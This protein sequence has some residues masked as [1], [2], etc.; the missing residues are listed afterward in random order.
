MTAEKIATDPTDEMTL[1]PLPKDTQQISQ[2][3]RTTPPQAA[4]KSSGYW[5][6]EVQHTPSSVDLLNLLR[7]YRT[8]EKA[9][10]ERTRESMRMGETDLVAL[11]HLLK[12]KALG[13]MLRQRDLAELLHISGA[14]VSVLVNRL[15]RDG[16]VS[17]VP[18]PEDRRSVAVQIQASSEEEVR[19]TL[20]VMHARM[21]EAVEVLS[22]EEKSAVA[23]F[24]RALIDSVEQG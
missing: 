23:K 22:E 10:R 6:G 18:H 4:E 16:Y 8:A 19:E 2:G 11:R 20:S 21:L 14:S 1:S 13:T 5:Y 12:A 3:T 24:L 9:M 17:R 7:T 15:E